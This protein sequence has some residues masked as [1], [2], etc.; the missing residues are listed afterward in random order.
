[1]EDIKQLLNSYEKKKFDD[2]L[3]KFGFLYAIAELAYDLR[4]YDTGGELYN[5]GRD[6]AGEEYWEKFLTSSGGVSAG[7]VGGGGGVGRELLEIYN[8]RHYCDYSYDGYYKFNAY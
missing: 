1:M 8:K 2:I 6:Y 7:P 3:D 4:R 5:I